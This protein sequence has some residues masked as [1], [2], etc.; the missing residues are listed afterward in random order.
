MVF[1]I[2]IPAGIGSSFRKEYKTHEVRVQYLLRA[3]SR[4]NNSIVQK[5]T[6]VFISKYPFAT[7]DWFQTSPTEL[8]KEIRAKQKRTEET[9]SC[10]C[11]TKSIEVED[12]VDV[13][14]AMEYI[15]SVRV[16]DQVEC[17][18][19]F[20]STEFKKPGGKLQLRLSEILKIEGEEGE[21]EVEVDRKEIEK[22]SHLQKKKS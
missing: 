12:N 8:H 17:A 3:S 5:E 22:F 9:T 7:I 1:E 19:K 21:I 14:I 4:V 10:F 2:L 18:V 20:S 16:G 15:P 6:P 13:K 11:M